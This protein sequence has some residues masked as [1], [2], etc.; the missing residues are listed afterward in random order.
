MG[1][2]IAVI[3][4]Q[5]IVSRGGVRP[6]DLMPVLDIALARKRRDFMLE[7]T[8]DLMI[9]DV[10]YGIIPG[11][12]KPCLLKPGAERLCSFFGFTPEFISDNL[13][14]DWTGAEHGGEPLF[15]YRYKC[16]ISKNGIIFGEGLGSCSTWESKYRYR[17]VSL[18]DIPDGLNP[19]DLK[20]RDGSIVEPEFAISKA[21]TSGK[22]GKPAE[23]WQAFKDAIE[24]GTAVKT[25]REKKGGGT[26]PAW[27]IGATIFRCPNP[28]IIDQ[29]NTALKMAVKRAFIAA[30]LIATNASEFYTQDL[31]D[32]QALDIPYSVVP[33]ETPEQV[34]ARRLAEERAKAEAAG[35]QTQQRQQP[36]GPVV[37]AAAQA[38]EAAKSAPADNEPESLKVLIL[39]ASNANGIR[40]ALTE[41][42]DL[43]ATVC[44]EDRAEIEYKTVAAELKVTTFNDLLKSV[45]L[46][47]DFIR[48]FYW[49]ID[50]LAEQA[51]PAPETPANRDEARRDGAEADR[52]TRS[53]AGLD[54]MGI[55]DDDLPPILQGGA[56]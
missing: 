23:Y 25:T 14:E 34:R 55:S 10:D 44:G 50:A 41:L 4:P 35:V 56:K 8:R 33:T 31:E 26:M 52:D 45:K 29:V 20:K 7:V 2:D 48:A 53:A 18:A 51:K 15:H 16:R 49:R 37:T 24:N 5:E 17:W 11:T 54:R 46:G 6:E 32:M 3:H 22:Y 38:S 40:E 27:Q 47:R 28:D 36:A 43:A 12:A 9:K 30:V 42:G 19:K 1:T 39:K 21:E 13:I